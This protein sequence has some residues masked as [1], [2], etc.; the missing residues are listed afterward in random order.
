MTAEGQKDAE[1]IAVAE[2]TY[3]PS[4]RPVHVMYAS[5]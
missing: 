1:Q 5:P 3:E 2:L 4:R